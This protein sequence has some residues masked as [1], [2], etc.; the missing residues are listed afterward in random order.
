METIKIKYHNPD[1]NKL[2]YIGGKSDW[3]DLRAA[4]DVEMKAGVSMTEGIQE[5]SERSFEEFM[6]V[7]TWN[8]EAETKRFNDGLW[9]ICPFCQKKLIKILPDTKIHKMPY[10]CKASK[11]KQ[12]FIVNVE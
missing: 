6:N 9:V 1:L 2:E 4:E 3:I 7:P 11:C 5:M 12:T 8:G 10:I